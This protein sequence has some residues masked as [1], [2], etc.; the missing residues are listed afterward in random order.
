MNIIC[1]EL[2]LI[3]GKVEALPVKGI[4]TSAIKPREALEKAAETLRTCFRICSSDKL[5]KKKVKFYFVVYCFSDISFC[6]LYYDFVIII[7]QS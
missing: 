7:E 6:S 4:H 3:A 5:V 1:L 2:R